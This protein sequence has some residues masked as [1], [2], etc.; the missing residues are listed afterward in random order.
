MLCIESQ[1]ARRRLSEL[2]GVCRSSSA[3]S[4]VTAVLAAPPRSVTR[5]TE[6]C[7]CITDCTRNSWSP[8]LDS[9]AIN[10]IEE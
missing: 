10:E 9:M 1:G 2:S 5:A 3:G 6:R 7:A 4:R 8:A